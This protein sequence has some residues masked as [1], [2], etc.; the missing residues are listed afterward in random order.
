MR[1][2]RTP[3]AASLP[4]PG[5]N[6]G[7][8]ASPLR[9]PGTPGVDLAR[10]QIQEP[11]GHSLEPLRPAP[12][13]PDAA[14]ALDGE[15]MVGLEDIVL[16]TR[17]TRLPPPQR[18]APAVPTAATP[19]AHEQ[20]GDP[21]SSRPRPA[22]ISTARVPVDQLAETEW[23][24]PLN[25]P[26]QM[27][28]PNSLSESS[29]PSSSPSSPSS[30]FSLS[31]P[32]STAAVARRPADA[33]QAGELAELFAGTIEELLAL[34]VPRSLD[35]PYVDRDELVGVHE[36]LTAH[37]HLLD[38]DGLR[39]AQECLKDVLA[40]ADLSA[41]SP[42]RLAHWQAASTADLAAALQPLRQLE[43]DFAKIR[44]YVV[45]ERGGDP[46]L[47]T[48]RAPSKQEIDDRRAAEVAAQKDAIK[49]GYGIY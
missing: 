9:R 19:P 4:A 12:S 41:V 25:S 5:G 8:V 34:R 2:S 22:P 26:S 48:R 38:K 21:S 39:D 15:R 36:F 27:E 43:T 1:A 11:S 23:Y 46:R 7:P 6:R 18:P 29:A 42:A 13:L 32:A 28:S 47:L 44:D 17:R 16:K 20:I 49:A 24:T 45:R 14:T 31:E 10:P 33:A 37:R 40:N 30:V 3:T 35:R